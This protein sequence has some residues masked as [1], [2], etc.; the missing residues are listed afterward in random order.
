MFDMNFHML[1][2]AESSVDGFV[3]VPCTLYAFCHDTL[4][5]MFPYGPFL[6]PSTFSNFEI[7]CMRYTDLATFVAID[8]KFVR[9]QSHCWQSHKLMSYHVLRDGDISCKHIFI[10]HYAAKVYLTVLRSALHSA[11]QYSIPYQN[12]PIT[13]NVLFDLTLRNLRIP[14]HL[15]DA[16]LSILPRATES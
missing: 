2:G 12:Q 9:L 7:A 10:Y 11:A 16:F 15:T 13:T 8:K 6:R 4:Q 3:Q 14:A 1:D 5:N